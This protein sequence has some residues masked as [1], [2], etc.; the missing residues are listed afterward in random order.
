MNASEK[1]CIK[2]IKTV[3]CDA[4]EISKAKHQIWQES[5]KFKN[6]SDVQLAINFHNISDNDKKKMK[7]Q[8][9][10]SM[11]KIYD[12]YKCQMLVTNC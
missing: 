6:E 7:K 3:E 10:K 1:I 2:E 11:S 9:L 12:E 5:R 8:K 4:C